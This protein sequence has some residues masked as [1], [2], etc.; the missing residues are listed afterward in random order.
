MREL[1]DLLPLPIRRRVA[2]ARQLYRLRQ[3]RILLEKE[4]PYRS[5]NGRHVAVA[6]LFGAGSGLARAA[7]L[8]ALTLEDRGSKVTRVD[9]TQSLGLVV[10]QQDAKWIISTKCTDVDI[11]DVVIVMNPDHPSLLVF[12]RKWLLGRTIVGHWIWELDVLPPFWKLASDSYDEIWAGTNLN[13]DTI[14]TNLPNFQRPLR[15]LPYA[16]HKDPLPKIDPAHRENVRTREGIASSTFVIGYSFSVDSNYYRKNPED[17][18]RSFVQAFSGERDVVLILRSH[19]LDNAPLE[20]RTLEKVIAGDRRIRI[21]D[22]KNR[23]S[24]HDFYHAIDLYF[25]S[26]RAEGYG[27]NLVEAAQAGLPVITSGWRIAPEILALPGVHPV[28]YD[29]EAVRD[30]QGHY[31]GIRNA[32]WSRP[33]IDEFSFVLKA[34]RDRFRSTLPH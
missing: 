15:L 20:R 2:R 22:G 1:F 13:L 34:M 6:G 31:A 4:R 23:L 32:V 10:R 19:D 7:E 27:L 14:K 8:A 24:I 5:F 16:I 29:L 12:D 18:V 21:Y 33:K 28:G 26:S 3:N 25:S 17:A 11:T 30:L 9:L